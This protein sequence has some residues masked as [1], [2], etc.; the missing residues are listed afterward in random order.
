VEFGPEKPVEQQGRK[1]GGKAQCGESFG[2]SYC[3]LLKGDCGQGLL[4][5]CPGYWSGKVC[6]LW[7]L[8]VALRCWPE[9]HFLD[10]IA[11]NSDVTQHL[12]PLRV[13][14]VIRGLILKILR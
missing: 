2:S 4:L 7:E 14:P 12:F 1:S 5:Y 13:Y 3:Q 8:N 9:Q 11:V 10:F 6:L